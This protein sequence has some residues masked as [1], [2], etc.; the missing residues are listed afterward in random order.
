MFFLTLYCDRC[1]D[2][3]EKLSVDVDDA[4]QVAID[5]YGWERRGDEWICQAC[6]EREEGDGESSNN[7]QMRK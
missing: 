4:A 1:D 7:L 2:R 3:I 6:A 5:D